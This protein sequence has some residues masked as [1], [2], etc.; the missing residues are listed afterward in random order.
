MRLDRHPGVVF[1]DVRA[2]SASASP[3]HG[4]IVTCHRAFPRSKDSTGRLVTAL[5]T[6]LTSHPSDEA[7][8]DRVVWLGSAGSPP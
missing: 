4:L 2:A 5:D 1:V 8:A 6:L 3:H 7:L